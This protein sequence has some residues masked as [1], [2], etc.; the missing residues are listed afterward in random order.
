MSVHPSPELRFLFEAALNEF[1]KRAGTNLVQHH[2][3]NKLVACES[4]ESVLDI[5][6]EQTKPLR[7]SRGDDTTLMKFI[8][9]TVHVLHSLSTNHIVVSGVSLV[10]SYLY[11]TGI[12]DYSS[13]KAFPPAKAVFAG[14]AILLSVCFLPWFARLVSSDIS[15]HHQAIKN[16]DKSY[17][18]IVDLFESFESFLRRLDV[19][20]KIPS[21]TAINKVIV[22]ILAELLSTI[23]LA[24]QQVKQG[25]FSKR[26]HL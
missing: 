9:R 18:T 25:R 17:D 1:E 12:L 26:Y 21:T 11:S 4:I 20:T 23:S 15:D 24:I 7:T 14:I 22:K 5:L 3:F 19:H 10:C 2:I 13:L 8:K 6:Q 16:V